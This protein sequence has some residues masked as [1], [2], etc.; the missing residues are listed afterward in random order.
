LP[1][2]LPDQRDRD[3]RQAWVG[4]L[5]Q[6]G[7][8]VHPR[9]LHLAGD[10]GLNMLA[11][12]GRVLDRDIQ[13]V[14]LKESLLLSEVSPSEW[15]IRL[16]LEA[17]HEGERFSLAFSRRWL[18]LALRLALAGLAS[19]APAP[20]PARRRSSPKKQQEKKQLLIDA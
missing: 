14:L 20:V 3:D 12:P 8:R 16:W 13:A 7:S 11:A 18:S 15:Q 1:A 2:L 9:H 6:D 4:A 17:G 19:V 5:L 10:E